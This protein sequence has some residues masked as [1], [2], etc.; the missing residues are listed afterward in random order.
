MT[1]LQ[2]DLHRILTDSRTIAVVGLSTKPERASYQVA[3]YL[4]QHGYRIVPVNPVYAG[5]PVLGEV[6]YA[7]LMDAAAALAP[8]AIDVVD[9]FRKPEDIG[10]VA[11]QAIAIKARCLWLQLG[12]VN[13]V[14]A[15]QARAAGLQVVMD[16]CMKI[17][18]MRFNPSA[19]A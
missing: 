9:C 8:L 3:H 14:A 7:T 15:D 1:D 10:P 13:Q 4:Q 6:C 19:A 18:H 11:L 5:R 17:E 12:I 16:R 2:P